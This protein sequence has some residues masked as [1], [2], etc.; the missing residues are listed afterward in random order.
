MAEL[1][2]QEESDRDQISITAAAAHLRGRRRRWL[3]HNMHV[4]CRPKNVSPPLIKY[5][6]A[7]PINYHQSERQEGLAPSALGWR[8]FG[9]C[10]FGK[11]GGVT[12]KP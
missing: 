4:L 11:H 12:W 2:G 1:D 10:S 5:Y 8:C 6:F 9:W 3:H 7:F